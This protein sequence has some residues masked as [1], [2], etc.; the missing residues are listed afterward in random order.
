[1]L[2]SRPARFIRHS[3][4]DELVSK[5]PNETL[6]RPGAGFP[7]G[8]DGPTPWNIIR[9]LHQII[10]VGL[11][12]VTMRKAVESFRHPKRAL[13]TGRALA[14]AFVR[15]KFGN[16]G[17]GF[18]DISRVVENDNRA[19]AGHASCTDQRIEIV[20]QI[21]HIHLLLGFAAI[22][23]ASLEFKFFAC[24][25]NFGRR[26]AGYERLEFPSI[27]QPATERGIVDQLPDRDLADL[28]FIVTGLFDMAADADDAGTGI[29]WR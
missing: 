14:T 16:V 2:F 21:E 23:T 15:V 6:D 29:I 17:K 7:E 11:S 26:T 10:C 5:F 18:D 13:T 1:M 19:R 20:R 22:R 9:D 4:R 12:T 28:D 8:A 24:L 27:A 25:E 3:S